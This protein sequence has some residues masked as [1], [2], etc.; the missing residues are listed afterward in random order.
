M[1]IFAIVD[2]YVDK[3][4]A[5]LFCSGKEDWYIEI[6]SEFDEWDLPFILDHFAKNGQRTVPPYW[7][8]RWISQRIVP[9][10]RQNLGSIL[11]AN[12]L[13][14]YDELKLLIISDGRCSQDDCCIKKIDEDELPEEIKKR[15]NQRVVAASVDKIS[16][17]MLVSFS[18]GTTGLVDIMK[19][20]EKTDFEKRLMA[21]LGLFSK[22]DIRCNGACVDFTQAMEF[23]ASDIFENLTPL[24]IT[25]DMLD[26]YAKNRFVS[27]AEAMEILG[28]SRQNIDDLVKRG[29]LSVATGF[30]INSKMLYRH[31]VLGLL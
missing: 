16:K 1:K 17:T 31:E 10:D 8:K 24:P 20:A 12:K 28:C 18:D 9:S 7:T 22:V 14:E 11:K 25:T 4:I 27:T 30:K 23:S 3:E 26:G 29:R 15:L 21:Y 6:L 19:M 5:Y 13:T 2:E